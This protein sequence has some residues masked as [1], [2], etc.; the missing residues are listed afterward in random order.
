MAEIFENQTKC[1][2][3][4]DMVVS[5]ACVPA[6]FSKQVRLAKIDPFAAGNSVQHPERPRYGRDY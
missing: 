4:K 3:R 1:E 5:A 6:D 2:E